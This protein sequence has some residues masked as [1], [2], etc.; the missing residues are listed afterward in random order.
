VIEFAENLFL[1][2]SSVRF[3]GV[4]IQTRM[5][6][7]RLSD[8]RLFVHSPTFL[9][10]ST[11]RRLEELG[12]VAFVV[13]T[14][15][16]HNL[17]LSQ[18]MEAFPGARFFASPGLV[19]RRPDLRFAEVLGDRPH[20]GW[21][22]DLD[23]V[24]TRGNVFF[25]E[26]LFLHR[27]SRTLIVADLVENFDERTASRFG[28]L[29]AAL[30]GVRARPVSSPEFRFFTTDAEAAGESLERARRWEFERI[31]LAHGG[32]IE[33]NAR[34]VFSEVCDDLLAR[35]RRRGALAKHLFALLARVQ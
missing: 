22:A 32:L 2:E 10:E 24:A 31:V 28:R 15:K 29:L 33:E 20:P 7:V 12:E 9:G 34:E 23:Q 19:E 16:I 30:F 13:A 5:S 17:A 14:N 8:G 11:R 21:A 1:E 3:Y 6:V 26:V 18:Y 27:R 25:S 35:V 4:R